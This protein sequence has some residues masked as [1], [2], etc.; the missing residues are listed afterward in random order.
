MA[1]DRCVGP[2]GPLAEPQAARIFDALEALCRHTSQS[3]IRI[4]TAVKN[5]NADGVKN[6]GPTPPT[7][8]L[9][10]IVRP[11]EPDEVHV[12]IALRQKLQGARRACNA[13]L[14]FQIRD[15]K[16]WR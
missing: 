12:R 14:L 6:S 10:Q 2:R 1:A 3:A 4:R 16:K 8:H 11:H 7:R 5:R 9:C 15:D 13:E